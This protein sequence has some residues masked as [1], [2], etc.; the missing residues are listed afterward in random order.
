MR[1]SLFHETKPL[2]KTQTRWAFD[3]YLALK[4]RRTHPDASLK[5]SYIYD[6]AYHNLVND[7]WEP[8]FVRH[9]VNAERG[10]NRQTILKYKQ[11]MLGDGWVMAVS[12]D[13]WAHH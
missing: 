1:A 8:A 5:D 6:V 13:I 10:Q 12:G 2:F 4:P 11:T 3:N 7:S 9:D